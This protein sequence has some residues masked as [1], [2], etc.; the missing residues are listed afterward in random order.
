MAV[1]SVCDSPLPALF[2][3]VTAGLDFGTRNHRCGSIQ[4]R[5]SQPIA[6][7]GLAPFT[8]KWETRVPRSKLSG[9]LRSSNEQLPTSFR[10]GE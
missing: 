4:S 9:R 5:P 3:L 2:H 7:S 1:H 10:E 6:D 8:P